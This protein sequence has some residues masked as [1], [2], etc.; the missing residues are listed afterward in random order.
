ML[1]P[2]LD[3]QIDLHV[4]PMPTNPPHK[5]NAGFARSSGGTSAAAAGQQQ[6]S[7]GHPGAIDDVDDEDLRG[8]QLADLSDPGVGSGKLAM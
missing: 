1:C 4:L 3:L 2:V 6:Q 7:G 5:K 8:S